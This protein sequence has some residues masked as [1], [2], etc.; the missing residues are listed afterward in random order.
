MKSYNGIA[1]EHAHSFV[2]VLCFINNNNMSSSFPEC[3]ASQSA[4]CS[5]CR[6]AILSLI[7]NSLFDVWPDL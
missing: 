5:L 7:K 3:M 6:C 1:C 2:S 4:E